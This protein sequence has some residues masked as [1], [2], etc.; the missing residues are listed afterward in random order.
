MTWQERGASVSKRSHWLRHL[1]SRKIIILSNLLNILISIALLVTAVGVSY[2]I[3]CLILHATHE[4]DTTGK[5]S[6]RVKRSHWL[7]HLVSIQILILIMTWACAIS[8]FQ[9]ETPRTAEMK[10]NTACFDY[11]FRSLVV[12]RWTLAFPADL[13]W[14]TFRCQCFTKLSISRPSFS[15]LV[16]LGSLCVL[17][18]SRT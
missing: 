4:H 9:W 1:V 18:A 3:T 16:L 2:I 15:S 10:S 6:Q 12:G 7:Q 8:S 13:H 17:G 11:Q 5:R 14:T